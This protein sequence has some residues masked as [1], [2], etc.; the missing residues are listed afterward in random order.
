MYF[1]FPFHL[2]NKSEVCAPTGGLSA[3]VQ[4]IAAYLFKIV[5]QTLQCVKYI[6]NE[7]YDVIGRL[8][9]EKV[10]LLSS[11]ASWNTS[12]KLIFKI[13]NGSTVVFAN[14]HASCIFA[15]MEILLH[16]ISI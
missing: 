12:E 2:N 10:R 8:A 15:Y 9:Y 6:T 5:W 14:V 16:E 11:F 7:F 3:R 4:A 13:F 1:S